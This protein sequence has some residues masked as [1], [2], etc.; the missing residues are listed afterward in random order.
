MLVQQCAGERPLSRALAQH[1]VLVCRQHL[2]PFRLGARHLE[3]LRGAGN[4]GQHGARAES[5]G[6]VKEAASALHGMTPVAAAMVWKNFDVGRSN[7][8]NL[9]ARRPKAMGAPF[10]QTIIRPRSSF[11]LPKPLAMAAGTWRVKVRRAWAATA[12][13]RRVRSPRG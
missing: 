2:A 9:T 6:T 10:E 7:A 3:G 1:G 13:S 11:A 4:A 12:A 5:G 8:G